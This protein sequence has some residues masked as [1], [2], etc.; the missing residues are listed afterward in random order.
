MNLAILY[1][2]MVLLV[3]TVLGNAM[4]W[5]VG[6]VNPSRGS[7]VRAWF[8]SWVLAGLFCVVGFLIQLKVEPFG[9]FE[10]GFTN[11]RGIVMTGLLAGLV[12]DEIKARIQGLIP[13]LKGGNPLPAVAGE[14]KAA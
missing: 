13:G 4:R 3:C 7:E 14:R 10:I 2:M 12:P 5:F 1:Y 8:Y 6:K 11:I 9:A